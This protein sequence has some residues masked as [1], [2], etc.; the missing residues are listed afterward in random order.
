MI[1]VNENTRDEHHGGQDKVLTAEDDQ[2]GQRNQQAAQCRF[3]VSSIL[4]LTD[5]DGEKQ[6]RQDKIKTFGV[7]GN[8]AADKGADGRAAY[9]VDLVE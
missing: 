4:P 3:M 7:K 1:S 2:A 8:T 5:K 6:R 9:P